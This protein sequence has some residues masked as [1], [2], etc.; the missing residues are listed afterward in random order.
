MLDR[1]TTTAAGAPAPTTLV[2]GQRLDQ[3]TFHALDQAMPPGTRAELIDGVVYMPSPVG[4]SHGRA[5]HRVS[6]WLDLYEYNT[7][8]V[9]ILDNTTT[10]L[11][12]RS[13]VQPDGLLRIL[14]E[15]GGRTWDE[16]EYV[17]GGPELVVEVSK[18]TRY[19]SKKADYERAGVQEYVVR[20]IDPDEIY[21]FVQEN[22]ELVRRSIGEDGLYRSTVFPGLWLDPVALIAGDRRRLLAA[23]DLGCATPEHAAFVARLAAARDAC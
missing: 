4:R 3:P 7:P 15:Y 23:V 12:W 13:E 22:G 14:P 11:G 21:W 1:T 5:T 8:G 2:D 16:G 10:I 18:A 20:A 6:S 19:V 17:G 9:E